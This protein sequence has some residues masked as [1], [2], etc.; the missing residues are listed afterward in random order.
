MTAWTENSTDSATRADRKGE[1]YWGDIIKSYN[2]GTP[3]QMQRKA[4]QAKDRWHKINRWCDLFE[5]DY[6]KARKVFTS[7]YNDQMWTD[8]A[9]E[10]YLDHKIGPFTIKNVWKTCRKMLKWKT[11]NDELKNACKRKS[12]HHEE[13]VQNVA[14]EDEMQSDQLDKMQLKRPLLLQKG[15]LRQ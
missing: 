4:K 3:P 12:Y 14:S 10:F 8:A 2:K 6:L 1:A 5:G 13:D 7:G 9:E 15:I 11:Y